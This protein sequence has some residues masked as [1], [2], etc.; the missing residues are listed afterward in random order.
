MVCVIEYTLTF[1]V[2]TVEYEYLLVMVLGEG[3][4]YF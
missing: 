3:T 2:V 4:T 1:A